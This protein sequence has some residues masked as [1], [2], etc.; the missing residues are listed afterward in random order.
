MK[1]RS[2]QDVFKDLR[3]EKDLS[4]DKIAEELDVSSS[5]VSKWENNQ[6]TPAPEMLEY[7]ADY[8]NVSVDYLIGRSKYKNL[9]PDNSEL[10]NALFSKAKELSDADKKV[11]LDVMNAIHKDIDK[12]LDN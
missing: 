7:I 2:F 3:L 1:D 9:E 5:L 8:F 10:E 4:Q 12:E 6:S 11:I